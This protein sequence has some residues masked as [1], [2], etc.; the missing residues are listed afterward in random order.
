MTDWFIRLYNSIGERDI[1]YFG[2]RIFSVFRFVVRTTANIILPIFYTIS[3]NKFKHQINST[4]KNNPKIIVSLTSFPKRI[5]RLWIVI[6]TLL[7]Q[8]KK[9]DLI[10]LWLSKNQFPTLNSLPKKLLKMQDRGLEII[11][12]DDDLRSHKKYFYILQHYPNDFVITVDDDIFYSK[13]LIEALWKKKCEF[14]DT[15][16]CNYAFE[17]KRY[18][19]NSIASYEKWEA[20]TV[21]SSPSSDIFFGSGGGTLFPPKSLHEDVLKTELFMELC[22]H[23]DDIWLNAMVRLNKKQIAKANLIS[24]V[25]PLQYKNDSTLASINLNE[26]QNNKQLAMVREYYIQNQNVDPFKRINN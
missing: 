16:I 15:I 17:I 8:T 23:A 11:L 1:K 12:V 25:L 21:E 3:K 18:D 7:R 4:Q 19:D 14:P 2:V 24:T 5:N 20:V 6:E 13:H 26:E 22:P 9:P 10:V